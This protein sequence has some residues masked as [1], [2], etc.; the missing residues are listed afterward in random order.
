MIRSAETYKTVEKAFCAYIKIV[1]TRSSRGYFR[2]QYKYFSKSIPLM[3]VPE[4]YMCT[5]A[6]LD[7][8]ISIYNIDKLDEYIDNEILS[9]IISTLN[10]KDKL[11]HLANNG[12][13]QSSFFTRHISRK[14]YTGT[15]IIVNWRNENEREI[16]TRQT[17]WT[18]GDIVPCTET[19][20]LFYQRTT[21]RCL[22]E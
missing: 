16:H 5:K 15:I 12:K 7:I 4:I 11:A 22:V 19:A 18:R 9:V 1:L 6:D 13:T 17:S 10:S 2:A 21:G 20:N 14:Q 3:E 8:T